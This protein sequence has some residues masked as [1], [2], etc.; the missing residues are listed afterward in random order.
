[1]FENKDKKIDKE[2]IIKAIQ[3]LKD[4]GWD[5][6]P[7]TLADELTVSRTAIYRNTEAMQLIVEERQGT[8]GIDIAASLELARKIQDLEK[9]NA[10]LSDKLNEAQ[11]GPA[12]TPESIDL[13]KLDHSQIVVSEREVLMPEAEVYTPAEV[14][15]TLSKEFDPLLNLNWR[16]IEAIYNLSVLSLRDYAAAAKNA[17]KEP[18][19]AP[20][21]PSPV[22][23][24]KV[25]ASET[26]QVEAGQL[27]ENLPKTEIED[28]NSLPIYPELAIGGPHYEFDSLPTGPPS[29]VEIP[30]VENSSSTPGSLFD[31]FE[32]VSPETKQEFGL[33]PEGTVGGLDFTADIPDL[34]H[35]DIF[36]GLENIEDLQHIH[37]IDD[38]N[39]DTD[40][41][42]ARVAEELEAEVHSNP[43]IALEE[44][45][46][47][48]S[49]PTE[50]LRSLINSRIKQASDSLAD[51]SI[52]PKV[53]EEAK[54]AQGSGRSK[55]VGGGK[56][57]EVLEKPTF[58]LKSVPADIRKACLLLGVRPEEL[59]PELVQDSW[60]R[61][62]ATPGVHPD[63]GGDTESAIYLNTAKDS[64]LH[65][66]EAQAPKLGKRFK[67]AAKEQ[68][69]PK[70]S[71]DSDKDN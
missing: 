34:D 49:V 71:N 56:P 4:R 47:P 30:A 69:K 68:S 59:T 65:W 58:V 64:L 6:N 9:S 11:A 67:Q 43:E 12:A 17:V 52:P 13:P 62:I 63:Q 22:E 10:Q 20:V 70:R 16:D 44:N 51:Q 42:N 21:Y 23:H 29:A 7:Y 60:K 33:L 39:L 35:L 8:F 66:L 24:H 25:M 32:P 45:V 48:S 38:V 55:F 27:S 26:A 57:Q 54:S 28:A 3:S 36:E 46:K 18:L 14:G 1:M 40:V 53:S 19:P 5:I 2:I 15:V 50:E 37:V 31:N 41:S 61:Q